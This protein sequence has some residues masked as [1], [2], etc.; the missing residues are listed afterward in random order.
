MALARKGSRMIVVN[1]QPFRWVVSPNDGWMDLVV[2]SESTG[3]WSV[4][5]E[6]DDQRLAN[7]LLKQQAQITPKVVRAKI[8][9]H[10]SIA[11]E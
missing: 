1:G 8:L 10:L 9:E 3:R 6:Y 4:Q 2:E 7:G 11:I 5:L